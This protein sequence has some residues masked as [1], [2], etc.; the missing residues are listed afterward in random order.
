METILHLLPQAPDETVE[1]LIETMAG[2]RW[3][4]VITLYDDGVSHRPVDWEKVVEAI[5]K[6]EKIFCWW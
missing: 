2:D 4:T 1:R 5:F 3:A 6:H